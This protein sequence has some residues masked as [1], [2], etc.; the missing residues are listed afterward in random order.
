MIRALGA[1]ALLLSI[2]AA[3]L[4]QTPPATA[5]QIR[6]DQARRVL[7]TCQ[8]VHEVDAATGAFIQKTRLVPQAFSFDPLLVW[9]SDQPDSL[10]FV[11]MGSG[12]PMKYTGC[13]DLTL[14]ADGQP[15]T[16]GKLEHDRAPD[17]PVEYI[18]TEIPWSEARK[19][20]GA[21]TIA[22]S[23]CKDD[24]KA[25]GEFVC[26]AKHLIGQAEAWKRQPPGKK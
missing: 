11:V 16:L 6:K 22:Y 24:Y 17:S 25:D 5:E 10:M 21:T 19:L 3:A 18:R 1:L 15:V 8:S 26:E 7:P 20:A 13:F 2:P 9:T 14:T 23:I 12:K 4:S